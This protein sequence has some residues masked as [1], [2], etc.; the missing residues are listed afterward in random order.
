MQEQRPG[1][2]LGAETSPYLLQHKENPVHWRAW[3]EEALAEARATGKPILLSVG[4]AACH[5]CHVMAHESFEDEAT[6][7]VMNDLF[8]NIKVDREERPDVDTI[9]MAALH[10]LGEQGGWPLTM[11]LTE[12][13]EPF[14]GGTYFP[15]DARYGRPAFTQVLEQVARIYRDEPAKVRQNADV[16]KAR[17]APKRQGDDPQPPDDASLAKIA[18]HL[19]QIV[20]PVHGGINGAPK[21]PQAQFFNF[22]WRAGLRYGLDAPLEAVAFTLTHIAQGG[23]YDHLGGG[24]SRYS[25]DER[26]LAPHFE[27]MLYDN[28]LLVELMT[29]IWRERKTPLLKLRIEE[30]ID[31]LLREMMGETAGADAAFAASLDADSEGEEGKFYVWSAAEIAEVLG[32]DDARSFADIYDVTPEGNWEH[33]NIINR[34]NNLDLLDDATEA[35]LTAMRAKLL[36]RRATRIRPGFDDKVLAD[37]NGLMI[38]ALAKAAETFVRPDWLAAPERAFNFVSTKMISGGR[39]FHAYRAGEAKAPANAADYANMIKA[40]LAL[41]N[42]TGKSAYITHARGFAEVLDRHYWADDLGGYYFAADDT[43]DLILRPLNAQDDAVPNANGVMVSNLMALY[44]W[45]G[46]ERYRIRAETIV[47]SFA[48]A[49]AENMFTHTGL[50]TG[51]MDVLAPAHIV[52]VVPEGGDARSLRRALSDAS[53]PGAVVREIREGESGDSHA[54]VPES[55]PAYGKHAIGGKPTAYVCIGP[56]CSAPV[57]EPAALVAAAREARHHRT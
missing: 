47:R 16:L 9:Y 51:A 14:W 11:F 35:R 15:K 8:V 22:L 6:A 33:H 23:I 57:T 1:N 20:D 31:W 36:V 10:E 46:E 7:A 29:E 4:Y 55:S 30:T 13:A 3:G 52:L 5:W 27:K 24:F 17:L 53:L 48:G 12:N 38:A 54:S 2:R 56:Q 26:W 28:A 45:T 43:R 41:A 39:L 49:I 50:L 34:I 19:T 42:V 40:A 21:F 25:V 37:W 32:P 18:A 44:L